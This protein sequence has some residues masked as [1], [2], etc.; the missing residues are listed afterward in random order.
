MFQGT[1]IRFLG[2][3]NNSFSARMFV[4]VFLTLFLCG[5][6]PA[7]ALTPQEELNQIN[8][9]INSV[10]SKIA[11]TRAQSQSLAN[12]VGIFDNQ[13]YLIQLEI[14]KTQQE[15]DITNSEIVKTNEQIVAAE[16]EL[17]KQKE[18]MS[19]YLRTMYIEGRIS[20]V[21]LV[22]G[23]NNFS[24]FVDRSEYLDTM[25]DRVQDTANK[26]VVLKEELTSKKN[27]LE[28]K[29]T[30]SEQLKAEQS[31]S[32][33]ILNDQRY[34]KQQLLDQTNG[35]EA[36]YSNILAQRQARVIEIRKA[37]AAA[38]IGNKGTFYGVPQYFQTDYP[39]DYLNYTSST[40]ASYGCGVTSIAMLFSSYGYSQ[41]PVSIANNSSY[42][43]GGTDL[44]SWNSLP[45]AS[46]NRFQILGNPY[47]TDLSLANEWASS[48]KPFIVYLD[49]AFGID[50][51]HF[52]IIVGENQNGWVM[53]DPVRGGGLSFND[54][55]STSQIIQTEFIQPSY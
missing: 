15:I 54:F 17:Q 11:E 30:K 22:A 34:A 23:S 33:Q 47:G 36:S 26:I 25:Q 31:N 6:N 48:G 55:Y 49:N 4:F 43:S 40:I 37:L 46:G 2:I 51:D 13:I 42:F 8:E 18:I 27:E 50:L 7:L 10:N 39:G 28:V 35:D 21:E 12:E 29:K 52:V 53:N 16:I 1:K 32:K 19:E 38:K 5:I 20:T 3:K 9:E 14:N 44:L 45:S 24:D 41:S